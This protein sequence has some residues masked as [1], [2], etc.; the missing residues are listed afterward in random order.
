MAG[1]PNVNTVFSA[2][3]K[4]SATVKKIKGELGGFQ[5]SVGGVKGAIPIFDK[6]TNATGGLLNPTTLAIGGVV[7]LGAGLVNAAKAAAQEDVGIQR[8]N[9]ALKANV[10][11]FN[12]NTAAIEVTI[13]QREKLAFS[14]DKLRE[15]LSLLVPAT[16]NVDEAL[17]LQAIAMDLARLRGTDLAETS[18]LISKVYQGN[19]TSLKRFGISLKGVTS[20]TEALAKIQ[21]L[22]AGQAEAYGGTLVGT[23]ESL[24]NKLADLT[25]TVGRLATPSLE[26]LATQALTVA[27]NLDAMTSSTEKSNNVWDS[28]LLG[29]GDIIKAMHDAPWPIGVKGQP[30]W[31]GGDPY[32]PVTKGLDVARHGFTSVIPKARVLGDLFQRAYDPASELADAIESVGDAAATAAD[33]MAEAIYGP[34][35]LTGRL[36]ELRQEYIDTKKERD[37]LAEKDDLTAKDRRQLAILDGKLAE[38]QS[39]I[40][41]TRTKLDALGQP[42]PKGVLNSLDRQIDKLGFATDAARKYYH[43]LYL[44][45]QTQGNGASGNPTRDDKRALGGPVL[46]G[47][48]YTVGEHGP[49]RLVMGARGGMVIA[50]GG[51]NGSMGGGGGGW[52]TVPIVLQ[53]DGRTV[54][55]TTDRYQLQR[56]RTTPV[57]S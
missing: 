4:M 29:L 41:V 30:D 16:K 36:A 38:T 8:L 50:G 48:S 35:I 55:E 47:R 15:S 14:D 11:G 56:L 12:G 34:T 5:K 27:D 57:S 42:L 23:A 33:Q 39:E 46:P 18:V 25:E 45:G 43:W 40:L 24:D 53:L 2:T 49:E 19:L 22:A 10:A 54:W 28:W 44:T 6:L 17:R 21:E 13:R 3:D 20:G 1:D 37:K 9:A 51:G 31:A 7:A 52:A 32:G 26:F